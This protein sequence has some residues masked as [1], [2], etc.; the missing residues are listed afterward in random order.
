LQWGENDGTN[1]CHCDDV[2]KI[3]TNALTINI[4]VC[5]TLK[6]VAGKIICYN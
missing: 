2:K 1:L 6:N 5:G 4:H 3:V